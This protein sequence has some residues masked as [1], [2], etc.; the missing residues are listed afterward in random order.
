LSRQLSIVHWFQQA[1]DQS[2]T[3]SESHTGKHENKLHIH[4]KMK[5]GALKCSLQRQLNM[6]WNKA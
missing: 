6:F 5:K 4:T 1:K 3:F 2:G